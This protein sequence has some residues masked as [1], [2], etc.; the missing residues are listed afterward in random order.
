MFN[1]LVNVGVAAALVAISSVSVARDGEGNNGGRSGGG[2]NE[3][4]GVQSWVCRADANNDSGLFFLGMGRSQAE[5]Y[6]RALE[7]CSRARQ[8]CTITCDPQIF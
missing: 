6:T 7:S 2:R 4:D 3:A 5:A 1:K 8:Q